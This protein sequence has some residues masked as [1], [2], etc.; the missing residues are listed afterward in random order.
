MP[1][2]ITNFRRVP[3]LSGSG[4]ARLENLQNSGPFYAIGGQSVFGSGSGAAA[5]AGAAPGGFAHGCEGEETTGMSSGGDGGFGNAMYHVYINNCRP[6]SSHPSAD[7]NSSSSPPPQCRT[8]CCGSASAG[9]AAGPGFG[10]PAA[11]G[12]PSFGGPGGPG[13]AGAPGGTGGASGGGGAG[14][15]SGPGGGASPGGATG[16]PIFGPTSYGSGS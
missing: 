11:S 15:S 14:G 8:M 12:G 7:R 3:G 6:G 13:G 4:P 2:L 9:G 5:N 16:P 10:G 1:F